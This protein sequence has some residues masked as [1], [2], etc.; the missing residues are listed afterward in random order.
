VAFW[1]KPNVETVSGVSRGEQRRICDAR[2]REAAR[3]EGFLIIETSWERRPPPERR[4]RS[5]DRRRLAEI[6]EAAGI[7]L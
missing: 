4:D 5:E 6:L 1:D 2:K 7:A 3:R